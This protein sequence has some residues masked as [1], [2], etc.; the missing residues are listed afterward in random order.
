[1]VLAHVATYKLQSKHN[2]SSPA[3]LFCVQSDLMPREIIFTSFY[4]RFTSF[5]ERFTSFYEKEIPPSNQSDY[6]ICYNYILKHNSFTIKTVFL[7]DKLNRNP[8][9]ST[10]C[11]AFRSTLR[12][13]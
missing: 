6:S 1:M 10:G 4:E 12:L 2:V 9:T 11:R 13:R 5:Y 7:N 8:Q 3:A